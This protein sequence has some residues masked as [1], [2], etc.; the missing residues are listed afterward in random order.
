MCWNEPC[1]HLIVAAAGDFV[2]MDNSTSLHTK[3]CFTRTVVRVNTMKPLVPDTDVELQ[4]LDLPM[5][6]QQFHYKHIYLL[7]SRCGRLGHRTSACPS[8]HSR[9][10]VLVPSATQVNS[11][12]SFVPNS[13]VNMV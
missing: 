12:Q 11:S 2:K 1:L 5:Y 3:G 8:V 7:C 13:D 10:S 4:G 6:W 9:T